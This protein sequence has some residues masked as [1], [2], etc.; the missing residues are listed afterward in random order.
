MILIDTNVLIHF[1]RSTDPKYAIVDAAIQA[2]SRQYKALN[3]VSQNL[4]EFWSTATRP[5]SSNGLGLTIPECV[6]AIDRVERLFPLLPDQ[7]TLLSEWKSVVVTHKCQGK[8]AH[9][10][11]LVAAMRIHGLTGILTFNVADFRRYADITIIDP[12]AF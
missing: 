2:L 10:A 11:R 7:P 6:H 8:T 9:D 4:Y 5:V 1:A 3:I 12:A